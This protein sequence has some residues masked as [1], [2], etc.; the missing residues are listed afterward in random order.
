VLD[1]THLADGA[2]WEAIEAFSGPVLASHCNCRSLV[3]GG[4]QLD[5]DQLEAI[6]DRDGVVGVA[7]DT[8]MLQED[9]EKGIYNEVTAT[10]ETVGDHIEYICDLAGDTRHVAIGSDLDGGYGLEQ[11]PRDLDTIA[12]LGRIADILRSRGYEETDVDRI[13]RD[14]WLGLLEDAW[15]AD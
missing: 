12:D 14:N 11:S 3:S 7:M 13:L 15:S 9:W 8:W 10:L 4:R 2:F 1:L 6:I 5:D